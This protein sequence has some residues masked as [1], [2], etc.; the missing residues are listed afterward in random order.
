MTYKRHHSTSPEVSRVYT[1][2]HSHKMTDPRHKGAIKVLED[3]PFD[4]DEIKDANCEIINKGG[5]KSCEHSD[6][7]NECPLCFS[8]NRP[9]NLC[10]TFCYAERKWQEIKCTLF[11][12]TTF[13]N[14]INSIN[15]KEGCEEEP[16]Y[17]NGNN[18]ITGEEYFWCKKH[19]GEYSELKLSHMILNSDFDT[20]IKPLFMLKTG[21]TDLTLTKVVFEEM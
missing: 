15:F 14:I 10:M 12:E 18:F 3:I 8:P 9:V 1:H 20:V 4:E 2:K 13:Q 5:T 7:V 17:C 6:D 19:N 11:I 21:T 16:E